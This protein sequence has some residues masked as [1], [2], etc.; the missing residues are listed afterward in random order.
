MNVTSNRSTLKYRLRRLPAAAAL[1]LLA[2]QTVLAQDALMPRPEY[3]ITPPALK[4]AQPEDL[5]IFTP[6]EQQEPFLQWGPVGF[7]PRM[8][9]RFLYGDGIPGAN[10]NYV[11][12]AIHEF[13][14]GFDF[15]L[16]DH[17]SLDYT[18][19]WT[20]YSNHDEF[21]DTLNH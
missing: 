10:T 1:G 20:M 15:R 6:Q 19:T 13:S 12:T 17:W 21:K 4:E 9:Y 11:T 5:Q 7:Q 16:G 8:F 3:S 18:P 14:P 2:A